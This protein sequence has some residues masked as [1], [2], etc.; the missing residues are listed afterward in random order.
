MST[1]GEIH[2]EFD[3]EI[4]GYHISWQPVLAIGMGKTAQEALEDLKAAAHF[5]IE[6]KINLKQK[7]IS[8]DIGA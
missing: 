1:N 6:T 4:R 8:Q 2:I 3:E 7:E 5:G